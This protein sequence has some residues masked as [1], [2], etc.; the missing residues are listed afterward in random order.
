M[1]ILLKN[2]TDSLV[3]LHSLRDDETCF[4]E[5]LKIYLGLH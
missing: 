1:E 2:E 4:Q 3:T 5:E